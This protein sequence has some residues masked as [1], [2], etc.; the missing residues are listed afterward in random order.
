VLGVVVGAGVDGV[1]P[2]QAVMLKSTAM[3]MNMSTRRFMIYLSLAMPFKVKLPHFTLTADRDS[4]IC[5][6]VARENHTGLYK[7]FYT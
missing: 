5:V 6:L 4:T 2:A 3:T 1:V 7:F